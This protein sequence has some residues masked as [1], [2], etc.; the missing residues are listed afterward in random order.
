MTPKTASTVICGAGVAGLAAA[1]YLSVKQGARDVL[2]V[3]E[4][5]PL[6]LTSDK[7]TECYRNWWPGPDDVMVTYMNRS[8]DLLE[9]IEEESGG[10][11]VLGRRGYLFATATEEGV[12]ELRARAEISCALGAGALREHLGDA[13]DPQYLPA[14]ASG[15]RDMPDGADLITDANLIRRRFPYLHPETRAVLHAR[16]CGWLSAQQ[17]GMYFLE[18]ARAHGVRLIRGRITAIDTTGGRVCGVELDSGQGLERIAI[19]NFVNAAGPHVG[20]V[21][22]MLGVEL[23]IH[24]ER[25]AKVSF[26]DRLGAFPQ[27]APMT[28]SIDPV[29]LVWSEEEQ[30]LLCE[31]EESRAL[32]DVMPSG[33]HARPAGGNSVMALW[34]YDGRSV[35]PVFPIT[36]DAHYPEI[37]LRGL[38]TMVPAMAG[39]FDAFPKH[40]VDGGYYAK[41]RENRPL[42]G[43]LPVAGAYVI[44]AFSGYGIMA[45]CAG[46]ELLAA[47]IA[48]AALP[49][50]APAFLLERYADAGYQERLSN[51]G[52]SGQ[53]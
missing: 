35:E 21:G 16:R 26:H 5:G 23:P 9:A 22:R 15:Y 45:S 34:T 50:Y 36:W 48:G 6:S 29:R 27:D 33:V 47:H 38:A 44:S 2:I 40:F 3:D 13:T 7:S 18:Q 51:W 25:R 42:I 46:G 37:V 1:Y 24:Y 39:Y 43:P 31:H 11:I 17:L 10:R 49:P 12:G 19:E 28:I 53:M 41:T 14:P 32:L 8:I 52:S 4:L 30:A 20:A